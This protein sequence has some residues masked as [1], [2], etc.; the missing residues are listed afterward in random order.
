M[1]FIGE[2]PLS[3]APQT[4]WFRPIA[5]AYLFSCS[6]GFTTSI[7]LGSLAYVFITK[8]FQRDIGTILQ[9]MTHFF[10]VFH[11]WLN[12]S[13]LLHPYGCFLTMVGS[14]A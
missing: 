10:G 1:S 8:R 13:N 11:I 3:V 14:V 4:A 6:V 12:M 2:P 9:Y 5:E 7:A